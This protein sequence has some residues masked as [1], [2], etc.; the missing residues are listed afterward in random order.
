MDL[1][2]HDK[3][4]ELCYEISS[5]GDSNKNLCFSY[6]SCRSAN[7]FYLYLCFNLK[8]SFACASIHEHKSNCIFNKQYSAEECEKLKAKIIEHMI[9]TGEWGEFFPVE[10]SPFS[11]NETSAQ[12][13]FP[14][15]KEEAL[16]LGFKW[17]D[18]DLKQ[19]KSIAENVHVC[20]KCNRNYKVIDSESKLLK[21][22]DLPVSPYCP[23][24]RQSFLLSLKNPRKLWDRKCDKCATS[25]KTTYSPERSE[26]V[27]CEKCYLEEVY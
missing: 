8:N 1:S 16:E 12:D 6:C 27:Y 4:I 14:L 13:S 17:R 25:I 18:D 7:S 2:T 22:L 11:Y 26:I 21:R 24:C 5:G 10:I 3:D 20:K 9:E 19:S 23:N 15:K